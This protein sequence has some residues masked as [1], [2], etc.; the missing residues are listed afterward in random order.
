MDRKERKEDRIRYEVNWSE[1][2]AKNNPTSKKRNDSK[3]RKKIENWIEP[4]YFTTSKE[5]QEET[6]QKRKTNK[7]K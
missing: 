6:I 4:L 2:L 1:I 7:V 3:E 5:D